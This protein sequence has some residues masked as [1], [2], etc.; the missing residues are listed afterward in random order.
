MSYLPRSLP[1]QGQPLPTVQA[2]EEDLQE[3]GDM[4]DHTQA[5][6]SMPEVVEPTS[7]ELESIIRWK[8]ILLSS[9]V[10]TMYV[11]LLIMRVVLQLCTQACPWISYALHVEVLLCFG[12]LPLCLFPPPLSCISIW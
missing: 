4:D 1:G 2:Q 3:S 6:Y 10:I 12:D 11:D 5:D 8:G 9:V 7:Y